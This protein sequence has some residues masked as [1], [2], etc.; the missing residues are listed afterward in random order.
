MSCFQ[1]ESSRQQQSHRLP[2]T[3]VECAAGTY[4]VAS[5]DVRGVRCRHVQSRIW[6]DGVHPLLAELLAR[7][8]G[9]GKQ[10]VCV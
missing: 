1:L 9:T 4:K 7:A 8:D 2:L 6:I 3:C 10:R 5:A